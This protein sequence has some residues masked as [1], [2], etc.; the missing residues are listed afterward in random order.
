MGLYDGILGPG[1]GTVVMILFTKLLKYNLITA[2]GNTKVILL[3]STLAAS[4]SYILAGKVIW[5]VAV[6]VSVFGMLGGYVG[7]GM[8]IKKG[9]KFIRPMM[10][11][12]A[13]FL[14]IKMAVDLAAGGSRDT[15]A[16]FSSPSCTLS[17]KAVY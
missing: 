15:A 16:G 14:V 17:Q 12:I 9:T 4:V 5:T 2:S 6:P 8:A 10:L 11:G 1:S 7:A 3:A 13:A